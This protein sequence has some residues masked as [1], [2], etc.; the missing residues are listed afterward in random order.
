MRKTLI[1]EDVPELADFVVAAFEYLDFDAYHVETTAAAIDILS[2]DKQ[3]S[4]VFINT[5]EESQINAVDLAKLIYERWPAIK[6][7]VTAD[8]YERL[9]QFPP[10]VFLAKPTKPRVLIF[11][12]AQ[13]FRERSNS[14]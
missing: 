2:T 10:C 8:R 1:I 14:N 5:S 11:A 12:I 4:A 9:D 13:A 3:F 7:F 6:I